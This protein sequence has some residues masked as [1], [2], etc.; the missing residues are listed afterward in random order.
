MLKIRLI[1]VIVLL[2][3]TAS[4]L[5]AQKVV[6]SLKVYNYPVREGVIH[7]YE[8]KTVYASF[9][10]MPIMNVM[11]AYDS[12]FHFEEGV[13][14]DVRKVGD[15]YAVCIE[16][17]KSEIVVYSNIRE[18]SLEKGIKLKRGTYL[19]L[20]D[21]DFEDEWHEVDLMIFQKGKEIPYNKLINYMRSHISTAPPASH[22]L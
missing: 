13:V 9:N 11:S 20:L 3:A 22:T 10:A 14:T 12:V 4:Q 6:D 17:K 15:V 8:P 7:I 16:N 1:P 2:F 19:G 21:R 18:T 5:Q